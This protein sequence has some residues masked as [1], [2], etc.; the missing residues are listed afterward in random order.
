MQV[1]HSTPMTKLLQTFKNPGSTSIPE[2]CCPF[3]LYDDATITAFRCD[4]GEEK[5]LEGTVKPAEVARQKQEAAALAEQL[6]PEVFQTTRKSTLQRPRLEVV[7]N[8]TSSSAE[9]PITYR[10]SHSIETEYNETA[11]VSGDDDI[12]D[13]AA[14]ESQS[15]TAAN[16]QRATVRMSET[17]AMEKDV[18]LFI[19]SPDGFTKLFSDLRES[20]G[21]LD[22]EVLFLTYRSASMRRAKMEELGNA[23]LVFV[24]SF[25]PKC[26]EST[27]QHALDHLSTFQADFVGTEV[28]KA[29]KKAVADRQSA[30]VSSTQV[31]LLTA[32][33]IW[34]AEEIT[35]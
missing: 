9:K 2:A 11:Q 23:L 3:P 24:K 22:V 31:I 33:E 30:E 5:V 32:S 17:S 18:I 25:P 1:D 27:V 20:M 4:V 29:L 26:S 21:E 35:E 8:V 7:V 16:S 34:Q 28:L 19:S 10:S 13:L 14:P 12:E 15:G 6:T